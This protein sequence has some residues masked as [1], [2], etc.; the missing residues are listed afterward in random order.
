MES[1]VSAQFFSTMDLKSGFWQVKMLEKSQQYTAFTVGSMGVYEFLWMPYRLCNTPATF[2]W[3]MQNCLGELNLMYT[4]IYLDDVIIFSWTEEEHLLWL[5]AVSIRF[6]EH[7]LKLKPS[8]CHFLWEEIAFLG[9]KVSA[10]GMKPEDDGLKGIV[11]MAP[12]GNYTEVRRFLGATRFFRHFIKNYTHIVKPL[13]DLLEGEASKFKTQ[14]VELPPEA[15]EAFNTLKMKCMM[16]LVLAFADFEKL[17][18]L[19]TDASSYGLGAML[20]Q[21][22]PDGK[23]TQ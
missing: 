14:P 7:G 13:H 12:L 5:W 21:K 19:E 8:K 22:Q 1:M 18:F 10:E 4:F 23:F 2:Q 9:H 3:L 16:A 15:L 11:E 17:F 20:S 6:W